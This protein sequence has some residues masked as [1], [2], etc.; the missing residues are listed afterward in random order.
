MEQRHLELPR[1]RPQPDRRAVA[2]PRPP[3]TTAAPPASTSTAPRSPAARVTVSIGSSNVWRIGAYGSARGGFFDG[4]I[5]NV[6]IYNRAL[7]PGEIT[8]G[9]EP[10]GR[11]G[12]P[13]DRRRRRRRLPA[14]SA[15]PVGRPGDA[16]AG[17]PRPTTSASSGTTSTASTTRR[18]HA[19]RL[20]TGSRSRPARATPTAA[21]AAGTYYYK[22]TAEDA[23]GNVGPASNEASA[24]VT[25]LG[26]DAAER[27]GR[28]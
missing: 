2:A 4:L 27:P 18:L 23:A 16:S 13:P 24:T 15:P 21:L 17:A 6:R 25:A 11:A 9:H 10:A 20:R 12:A 5:D 22:V 1:L 28:R 14:R 8:D 26:H 3:P 7:T 19:E